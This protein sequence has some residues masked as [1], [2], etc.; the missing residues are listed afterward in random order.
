ME[1]QD[2]PFAELLPELY[3]QDETLDAFLQVLDRKSV[4]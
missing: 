2:R 1:K 4:V 3:Q